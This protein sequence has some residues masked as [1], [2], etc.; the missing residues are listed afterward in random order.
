MEPVN[1]AP[2]ERLLNLAEVVRRVSRGKSRI[3]AD[4]KAGN[5]PRPIKDGASTRFL[6]S[7]I[8]AWIAERRAAR[9][10]QAAA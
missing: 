8:D 10:S 5:F 9:D 6:E 2:A 3:Y 1:V 7:E 4:I